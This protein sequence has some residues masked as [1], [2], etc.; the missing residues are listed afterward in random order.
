MK[1]WIKYVAAAIGGTIAGAAYFLPSGLFLTFVTGWLFL[2]PAA[3]IAVLAYGLREY[4]KD[5][6]NTILVSVKP[7]EAMRALA[8]RE[9]ELQREKELLLKELNSGVKQE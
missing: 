5:R 9:M 6:K 4:M 1:Y 7:S 2:I 8:R 3:G